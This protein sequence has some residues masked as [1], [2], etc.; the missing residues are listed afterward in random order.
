[1]TPLASH[2]QLTPYQRRLSNAMEQALPLFPSVI[3][4]LV[5][6]YVNV[7]LF[8][9]EPLEFD[10]NNHV[11]NPDVRRAI[12]HALVSAVCGPLIKGGVFKGLQG[13]S[14]R[15]QS[16]FISISDEI[17]KSGQC[18]NLDGMILEN[19]NF[20]WW[21]LDHLSARLASFT[22][23]SFMETNLT[24]ANFNHA[25]IHDSAFGK[26][27]MDHATFEG[28]TYKNVGF[29]HASVEGMRASHELLPHCRTEWRQD[30]V[31]GL[32]SGVVLSV[33]YTSKSDKKLYEI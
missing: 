5:S 13:R 16:E 28:V 8:A 23:T 6:S 29:S 7:M 19:V 3:C 14:Q 24:D 2:A 15:Y 20:N 32:V 10:S 31:Y 22:G 9:M 26:T 30:S 12:K 4:N 1:M 11:I 27:R 33:I 17:A 25:Y 21:N 18:V